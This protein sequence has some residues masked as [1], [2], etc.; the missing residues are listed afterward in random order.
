MLCWIAER[1]SADLHNSPE[2]VFHLPSCI[3]WA[4]YAF[5]S[6]NS[7]LHLFNSGNPQSSD[8][9]P[10]QWPQP[11]NSSKAVSWTVVRLTLLVSRL[12]DHCLSLPHT[13]GLENHCFTY[14]FWFSVSSDR[15]NPVAITP[16]WMKQEC[17]LSWLSLTL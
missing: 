17:S 6:L 5:I 2:Q 14:F 4:Q 12:R 9:V 8:W 13:Q 11:G 10:Y 3:L 15:V 1:P 16:S 7:Q